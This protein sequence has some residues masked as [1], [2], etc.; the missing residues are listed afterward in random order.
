MSPRSNSHRVTLNQVAKKAGVSRSTASRAMT[1]SPEI[2]PETRRAVERAAAQLGYVPNQA[3]RW[4]VTGRA[5]SVGL[6]MVRPAKRVFF[7]PFLAGIVNEIN[8]LLADADVQ[9][10]MLIAE[11]PKDYDRVVR[12]ATSGHV[13]GF[14]LFQSFHGN[15]LLARLHEKEVPIVLGGRP[16]AGQPPVSFVDFDNVRAGHDAVRHLLDRGRRRIAVLAGPTVHPAAVDRV[17]G[18]RQAMSD[19]GLYDENLIVTSDFDIEGGEASMLRVLE[20]ASDVDAVVATFDLLGIGAL[21]ALRSKGLKVPD[22]VAVVAFDDGEMLQVLEP[23]LTR[24]SQNLE[25]MAGEM[26]RQLLR[27]ITDQQP[28]RIGITLEAELVISRST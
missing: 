1:G 19:A 13:D 14:L 22:D 28:S 7:Q 10:V 27:L 25:L 12:F 9:L 6:V 26:V 18:Y 2:L 17:N 20:A 21:R 8:R 3:A 15:P 4:L 23:D 11:S 5:G 16:T 24:L